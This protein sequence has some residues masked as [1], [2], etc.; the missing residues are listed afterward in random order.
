MGGVDRNDQLG[1]YYS[2]A[3][4]VMK[5]WKKQF[6]YLLNSMVLQGYIIYLKYTNDTPKKSHFQFRLDLVRELITSSRSTE[7]F[8]CHSQR[9]SS[10][11]AEPLFRL[12]ARHF[13]AYIPRTDKKEHPQ[14]KCVV[15][16]ERKQRKETI[17]WCRECRAALCVTPCFGEYH[18]K[19]HFG[20]PGPPVGS[21]DSDN[22]DD[23]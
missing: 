22:I 10:T 15:C 18:K 12:V 4:K 20:L 19:K 21:S 5:V 7:M 1:K 23:N 16:H 14:R 13:P 6:F 17:Y 11:D 3:R 2:F 8:P 9:R